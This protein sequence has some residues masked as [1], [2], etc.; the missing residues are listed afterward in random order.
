MLFFELT[1]GSVA[2]LPLMSELLIFISCSLFHVCGAHQPE[3]LE[4]E[5]KS[6]LSRALALATRSGST[7]GDRTC[8]DS[9]RKSMK[10]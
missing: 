5:K 9:D 4:C 8:W 2:S 10:W 1:M 3:K 6:A 7:S